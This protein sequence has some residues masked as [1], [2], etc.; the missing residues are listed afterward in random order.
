MSGVSSGPGCWEYLIYS[1]L[2]GNSQ[3][4]PKCAVLMVSDSEVIRGGGAQKCQV[5]KNVL[6]TDLSGPEQV[7]QHVRPHQPH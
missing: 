5:E 1:L 7:R 3:G 2:Q 6:L 4:I